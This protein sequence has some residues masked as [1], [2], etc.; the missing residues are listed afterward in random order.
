MESNWF[1]FTDSRNLLGGGDF[2]NDCLHPFSRSYE[3]VNSHGISGFCR[4]VDETGSRKIRYELR[5]YAAQ[6]PVRMHI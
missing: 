2:N 3:L 1:R 5:L 6:C 4:K